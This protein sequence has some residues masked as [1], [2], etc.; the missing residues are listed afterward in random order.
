MYCVSHILDLNLSTK[1]YKTLLSSVNYIVLWWCQQFYFFR[2]NIWW[3]FIYIQNFKSHLRPTLNLFFF[4][5]TLHRTT[6][7]V[8]KL[9]LLACHRY[10]LYIKNLDCPSERYRIFKISSYWLFSNI[11]SVDRKQTIFPLCYLYLT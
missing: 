1:P 7:S 11:K 6:T 5:G 8:L 4:I 3:P 10:P 2:G 9:F